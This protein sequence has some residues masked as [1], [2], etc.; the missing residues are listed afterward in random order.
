MCALEDKSLFLA[1]SVSEICHFPL[2]F[3]TIILHPNFCDKK[4]SM[5]VSSFE[6]FFWVNFV[7]CFNGF[8]H[9]SLKKVAS[10]KYFPDLVMPLFWGQT[11]RD[12]F[13]HQQTNQC[14]CGTLLGIIPEFLCDL[15]IC[16]CRLPDVVS[17]MHSGQTFNAIAG[18]SC[19][20]FM[21]TSVLL[22]VITTNQKYGWCWLWNQHQLAVLVDF[23]LFHLWII[24][25]VA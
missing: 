6:F 11:L 15:Y 21:G 1:S 18:N 4:G 20:V 22:E 10:T 13:V 25:K 12:N 2:D 16:Y 7:V 19:R 17:W 24:W 14:F 5:N 9:Y 8:F 23:I 3:E